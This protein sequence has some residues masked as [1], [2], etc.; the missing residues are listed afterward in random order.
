MDKKKKEGMLDILSTISQ[1]EGNDDGGIIDKL[2]DLVD[3]AVDKVTGSDALG[4]IAEMG[5]ENLARMIRGLIR[6]EME[7][8]KKTS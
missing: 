7:V 3:S 8:L 1:A 5:A 2:G 4:D 6:K